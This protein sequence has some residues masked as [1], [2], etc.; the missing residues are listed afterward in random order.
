MFLTRHFTFLHV[1]RTGGNFVL[2][3]LQEHA[4]PD[5]QVQRRAD[6]A[7][8]HDIPPSHANLPRL[9]FVRNPYD[10]YVSWYHFQQRTRDPF[11]LEISED[12]RLPFPATMRRALNSRAAFALG[13]GPFTQTIRDMLGKDVA[14]IRIGRFERFR[15]DLHR[16]LTEVVEIPA[17]MAREIHE[18]TPRNTSAHDHW[19]RYY[20]PELRELIAQKDREALAFFGYGWEDAAG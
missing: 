14:G 6:H 12:G 11:F 1:P 13:E 9:A 2:G 7:T 10:W 16:L 8:V 4:P 20:D 18:R 19:S 17:P 5:W 15:D 3:L